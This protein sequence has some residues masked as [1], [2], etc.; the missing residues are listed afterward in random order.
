MKT[1]NLRSVAVACLAVGIAAAQQPARTNLVGAVEAV[2]AANGQITLHTDDGK[3]VKITPH[4]RAKFL[5]LPP[6][7]KS[8]A[9]VSQRASVAR[10]VVSAPAE[11]ATALRSSAADLTAAGNVEEFVVDDASELTVEVTL[12]E[13]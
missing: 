13:S 8:M 5:R 6:G 12:S 3:T 11:F 4:E 10:L 1:I 9:K 7:E 2:D